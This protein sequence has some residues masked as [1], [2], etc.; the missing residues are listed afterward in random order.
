MEAHNFT[1]RRFFAVCG[2]GAPTPIRMARELGVV[3]PLLMQGDGGGPVPGS[4]PQPTRLL[5]AN[6]GACGNVHVEQ[7][8]VCS[9]GLVAL[10]IVMQGL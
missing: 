4:R 6:L 5:A 1:P 8:L 7:V 3:V 2:F 10:L 9:S